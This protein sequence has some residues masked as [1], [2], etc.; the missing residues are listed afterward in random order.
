MPA[1]GD[2]DSVT[3][4]LLTYQVPAQ[5]APLKQM[6]RRKLIAIGAVYVSRACA[7]I[8]FSAPAERVM[9][10]LRTQIDG[11]GGRAVL[12]RAQALGGAAEMVEAFN[13]GRDRDYE[14]V[15]GAIG[16]GMSVITTLTTAGDFSYQQ[17]WQHDARLKQL[18]SRHG[19][20]RHHDVFTAAQA[21][22]AA[23]ALAGYRAAID[24]YAKRV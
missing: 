11:A 21:G 6:I 14:T 7:T 1:H 20:I 16:D 9:R 22:V 17:L 2:A 10:R 8:P 18:T 15:I 12:L 5:S 23:A 24:E 3:W 19:D 4:L 13:A